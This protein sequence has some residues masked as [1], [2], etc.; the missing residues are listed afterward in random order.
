M[1]Y[2]I[3]TTERLNTIDLTEVPHH[4]INSVRRSLNGLDCI[5]KFD[6]VPSFVTESDVIYT[7]EQMLDIT[8]GSH[9]SEELELI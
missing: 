4:T 8:I 6:T 9:W 1:K 3:I 5:L 2:I 7:K